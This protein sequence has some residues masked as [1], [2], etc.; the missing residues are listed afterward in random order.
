MGA[1]MQLSMNAFPIE[2]DESNMSRG[3]TIVEA[4]I[5]DQGPIDNL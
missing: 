2:C 1:S 5:L 3:P 4:P